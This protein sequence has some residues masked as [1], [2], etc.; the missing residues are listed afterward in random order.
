M[1]P[2]DF[3]LPFAVVYEDTSNKNSKLGVMILWAQ[4]EKIR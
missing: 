4:T 2:H 1:L 3:K